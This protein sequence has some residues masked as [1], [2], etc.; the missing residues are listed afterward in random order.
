[1][2]FER[3]GDILLKRQGMTSGSPHLLFERLPCGVVYAKGPGQNKSEKHGP[4]QRAGIDLRKEIAR[5]RGASEQQRPSPALIA[6][7]RQTQTARAK[8]EICVRGVGKKHR[9]NVIAAKPSAIVYIEGLP[10]PDKLAANR[11][12]LQR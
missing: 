10:C 3:R 6:L 1:L 11:I 8:R 9:R 4:V 2:L 7:M 5:R 12:P